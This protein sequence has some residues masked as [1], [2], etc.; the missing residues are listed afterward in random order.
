LRH[1]GG[2]VVEDLDSA[3][4]TFINGSTRVGAHVTAALKNGDQLMFG[5]TQCT[6][7]T[8]AGKEE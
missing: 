1:H 6:F 5:R 2:F 7:R 3:N 8:G 4:G